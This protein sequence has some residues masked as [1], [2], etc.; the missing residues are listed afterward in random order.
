VRA[1]A[2]VRLGCA[3]LGEGDIKEAAESF[4]GALECVQKAQESVGDELE[5][6][7]FMMP[8]LRFYSVLLNLYGIKRADEVPGWTEML[9]E[10]RSTLHFLYLSFF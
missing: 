2:Y 1:N 8:E 4:K 9:C 5:I 6:P 10:V 7:S 3:H